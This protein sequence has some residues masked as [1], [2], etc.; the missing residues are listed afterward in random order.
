MP[1]YNFQHRFA[2]AIL[3]GLKRQ[4]IR[5]K[6]NNQP[7]VGQTAY[8][9][10]GMRTK[11]CRRLVTWPIRRVRDVMLTKQ[12]VWLDGRQMQ[13]ELLESF[14]QADGFSHWPGM[15]VWFSKTHG[16]PFHGDLVMW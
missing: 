7:R 9:F 13:D 4:T 1:S 10:T 8:C 2:D 15:V 12:G 5:A 3:R 16:L 11:K 14:A 6:R